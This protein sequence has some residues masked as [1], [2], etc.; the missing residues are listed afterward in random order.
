[1]VLNNT[2]VKEKASFPRDIMT[3][4]ASR[5]DK[6]EAVV[7]EAATELFLEHGYEGTSL[8]MVIDRAGGSRRTIYQR[9]GN[10]EGLFC[11]TV[12]LMLDR[13][14][15][16][17]SSVD[18]TAGSTDEVLRKAGTAFVSALTS[19]QAINLFRIVIAEAPRFPELASVMFERGPASSY[20]M[21]RDSLV[22]QVEAGR[23][24]LS[25]PGLAARQLVEMMKG[26]LYL[27]ALM[28]PGWWPKQS[29]IERHVGNAVDT[30][31]NGAARQ[32]A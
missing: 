5:G 26:D 13:L 16:E 2:V 20:A 22:A 27:R 11:A 1:M 18:W 14:L 4:S 17:L 3:D 12:E 32:M 25:D 15:A 29:E 8:D 24:Q 9:F 19:P 21:V 7:L 31:L 30:F 23:M 6:R 10:K 28:V